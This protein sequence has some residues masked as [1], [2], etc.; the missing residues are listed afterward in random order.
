MKRSKQEHPVMNFHC[1]ETVFLVAR[2][3]KGAVVIKNRYSLSPL[4]K[5]RISHEWTHLFIRFKEMNFLR[6]LEFFLRPAARVFSAT[7]RRS[8][9]S[10]NEP[11][12]PASRSWMR[13]YSTLSRFL[14]NLAVCNSAL[15]LARMAL[16]LH[17]DIHT[18]VR[19]IDHV[20][21]NRRRNC[22]VDDE[23]VSSIFR[24]I[25]SH[26]EDRK[27]NELEMLKGV[28]YQSNWNFAFEKCVVLGLW[29]K[30]KGGKL[31]W[32]M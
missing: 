6:I 4:K 14:F 31:R 15:R 9:A 1:L 29:E 7:S 21:F 25:T 20:L 3:L 16:C 24:S 8:W 27:W 11:A 19:R 26:H 12:R 23:L 10:I 13:Q 28:K 17:Q 32:R 2:V 22:R 18:M 30:E 5:H